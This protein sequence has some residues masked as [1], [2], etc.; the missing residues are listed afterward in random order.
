MNGRMSISTEWNCLVLWNLVAFDNRKILILLDGISKSHSHHWWLSSKRNYLE[1]FDLQQANQSNALFFNANIS[2]VDEWFN[3]GQ[4]VLVIVRRRSN[5]HWKMQISLSRC[6]FVFDA[7][8][9]SPRLN[10][11]ERMKTIEIEC[12]L[13]MPLFWCKTHCDRLVY[14]LISEVNRDRV[15]LFGKWFIWQRMI[16]EAFRHCVSSRWRSIFASIRMNH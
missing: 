3:N 11:S 15:C 9:S 4:M 1:F 8:L 6:C 13:R 14:R 5:Y 2:F 10:D 12:G 7:T 16:D